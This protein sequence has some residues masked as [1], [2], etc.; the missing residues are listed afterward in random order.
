MKRFGEKDENCFE[1]QTWYNQKATVDQ[2]YY[3]KTQNYWIYYNWML[4]FSVYA[5]LFAEDL[6][7]HE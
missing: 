5:G 1:N 7:V 3:R 4:Y 6:D 2:G